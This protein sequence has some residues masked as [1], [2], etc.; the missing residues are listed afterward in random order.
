MNSL[1]DY[2]KAGEA[3]FHR[4]HAFTVSRRWGMLVSMKAGNKFC[5]PYGP[6]CRFHS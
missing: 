6:P 1:N 2:P 4:L 3:V 5:A